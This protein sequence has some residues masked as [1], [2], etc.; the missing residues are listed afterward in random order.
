MPDPPQP[1]H[2]LPNAAPVEAIQPGLAEA[3]SPPAPLERRTSRLAKLALTRSTDAHP[4]HHAHF[5]MPEGGP[6]T[7]VDAHHYAESPLHEPHHRRGSEKRHKPVIDIEHVPVDDDPRDWPDS[8]K[9]F[10]MV[11]LTVSVLGP[12]IAPSIYNPVIDEVQQDLNASST[13]IGLSISMYILFQGCVP[14]LW[15]SIAEIT[16]RKIVYLV[17]YAIYFVGSLVGSRANSMPL[18]I[19]MRCLQACGSS[20][21]VAVGAGSLA[22]MFEV[23]ERGQKLG[24][25]YGMPLVGPAIGPLIGGGLGSA[26]GWRSA[27]YFLAA[28]AAVVGL[29]FLAFPDTWRRERSRVYQKAMEDAVKRAIHNDEAKDKKR[30]RKISRGLSSTATTPPTTGFPSPATSR[31]G[32]M[33]DVSSGGGADVAVAVDEEK[34]QVVVKRKWWQFGKPK[35]EE[36]HEKIKP[37]WRDVNP[38]P[39]MLSIFRQPTNAV[40][41]FAS[42]I[43]FAAQYTIVY[44]ASITLAAAPYSYNA[45]NIGLVI[46]SFGAGSMVGSI[47]GG[48]YSDIILRKLK[49]RNCG[50]SQPEMRLKSTIPA[51]P[52]VVASFLAY[53]WTAD[54]KVH[55]SATVV[56]LFF[57]GLT[58]MMIYASTLAYLVDSNPGRSAG[59]V[60]CNSFVR[61]S[62]GCILSQ[63]AIP[64]QNAIGDGGLYSIVAGLLAISTACLLFI[65]ANG[66]K[67]RRPEHRWPW[68]Q[69]K[70][71]SV[72]DEDEEKDSARDSSSR[73]DSPV[74][75]VKARQ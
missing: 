33:V 24:V 53:G 40:V 70:D 15:A 12:L 23:H 19:V 61:G 59:A 46:L 37:G 60:S 26:F 29:L 74:A 4:P 28:Y 56:T 64:I 1:T 71:E 52:L 13:Q 73:V 27:L 42:G 16:G 17:S 65:A 48:R 3:S 38:F 36:E 43:L 34:G 35:V 62:L 21:V 25:F 18:F 10:V 22:D 45:L 41:L 11:L 51:V 75:D 32:S 14:V 47:G 31:R 39:T 2:P 68:N 7:P 69:R 5:D 50:V 8:K 55:I 58:L 30:A 54:R 6:G 9:N 66:E 20:A 63:V 67:W 72:G 44:T 57:C 49:E